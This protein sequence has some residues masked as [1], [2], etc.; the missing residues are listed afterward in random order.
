MKN[1]AKSIRSA[2]KTALAGIT[3]NGTAV[4]VYERAITQTYPDYFIEIGDVLDGFVGNDVKFMRD[5]EV[6]VE[7]FT[8]Q[9]KYQNNTAVDEIAEDVMAAIIPNTNS[10]AL[11]TTDFQVGYIALQNSR[12]LYEVDEKGYNITR[13]IMTFTQTLIQK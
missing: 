6:N 5:T 9:Y 12:Y 8:R 11:D 4:P 10:N 7:V 3:Y 1:A 2:Y 13:K